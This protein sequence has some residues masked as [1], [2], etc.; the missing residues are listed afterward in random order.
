MMLYDTIK[1]NFKTT[2]PRHFDNLYL[3]WFCFWS[4]LLICQIAWIYQVERVY[5][6]LISEKSCWARRMRQ[7][8][9][10]RLWNNKVLSF[11]QGRGLDVFAARDA[12]FSAYVGDVATI[13]DVNGATDGSNVSSDT[14]M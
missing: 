8:Y 2:V 13:N 6:R 3:I 14:Q 1:E 4:F 9:Q 10:N 12:G 11:C 5:N 7:R